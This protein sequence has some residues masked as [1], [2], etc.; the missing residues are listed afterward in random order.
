MLQDLYSLYYFI[1]LLAIGTFAIEI[2]TD[3]NK[4]FAVGL[5]CNVNDR[6]IAQ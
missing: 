1:L 6:I 3:I 4:S 5:K 2:K